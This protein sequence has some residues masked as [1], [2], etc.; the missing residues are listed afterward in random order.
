MG[1]SDCRCDRALYR[2]CS[3][4]ATRV[5]IVGSDDLR[6]GNVNHAHT[7]QI[8]SLSIEFEDIKPD[9]WESIIVIRQFL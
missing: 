3:E 7:A 9:P 8:R 2:L 1:F 5:E 4:A 6:A